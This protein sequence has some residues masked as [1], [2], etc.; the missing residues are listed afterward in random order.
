M[1]LPCKI[2][3]K[4]V[5]YLY[6]GQTKLRPSIIGEIMPKVK[7][8]RFFTPCFFAKKKPKSQ[9]SHQ[10]KYAADKQSKLDDDNNTYTGKRLSL[11]SKPCSTKTDIEYIPSELS[12]NQRHS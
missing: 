5:L 12:L 7:L 6:T 4:L 10:S 1:R 11:I 2:P 8:A 9:A 3:C